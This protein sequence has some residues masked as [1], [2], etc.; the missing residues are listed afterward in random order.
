MAGATVFHA[1]LQ[2]FYKCM[3]VLT[4]YTAW[5]WSLYN[6]WCIPKWWEEFIGQIR[7]RNI[8]P[9]E[10]L[11]HKHTC[12]V[13][14]HSNQNVPGILNPLYCQVILRNLKKKYSV[15]KS[16]N[17]IVKKV[18]TLIQQGRWYTFFE[19]SFLCK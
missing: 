3:K 7:V 12:P 16:W 4:F 18:K 8:G 5:R 11:Q 17:S 14:W 10:M 15:I 1:T 19:F 9:W 13:G 2:C 6:I